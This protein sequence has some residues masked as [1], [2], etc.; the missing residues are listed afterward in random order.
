MKKGAEVVNTRR[1][2]SAASETVEIA[3]VAKI[4]M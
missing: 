3:I 1:V 4:A 2:V